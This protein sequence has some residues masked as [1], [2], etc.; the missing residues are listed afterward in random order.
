MG[1]QRT[2]SHILA[3]MN[4]T[5]EEGKTVNGVIGGAMEEQRVQLVTGTMSPLIGLYLKLTEKRWK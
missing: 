3:I 1:H 2:T 5:E 4:F